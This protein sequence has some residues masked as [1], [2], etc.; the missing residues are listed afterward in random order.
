MSGDK[1]TNLFKLIIIIVYWIGF[2]AYKNLQEFIDLL[3]KAGELKRISTPVS[4]QLEISEITDRISKNRGPALLF[5]NTTFDFPVLI[6]AFGSEKRMCLALGVRDFDEIGEEITNLMKGLTGP[7]AGLVDKLKMLPALREIAS[8]MPKERKGK[9]SCQEVINKEPDLTKIPVITCWPL[10]GGPYI[11]LPVVH[12]IDPETKIRNVGMYRMQVFDK[13][14]TGMHWQ[15]HKNSARHYHEYKKLGLKMPVSVTLGGDPVYT[16]AATAPMPDNMDEYML[17][18]FLRKKKVELVKCIT[19]DIYVPADADFVLEGYVDPAEDPVLEGPFGDHTG[20]YSLADYYPKFHITC[21]TH[22]KKAI[23]PTT[24]VG[25]PPQEDEW[26]G[27]ATERIFLS[28]IQMTMLPEVVDMVMPVEGVFHNIAIVK[29]KKSYAGQGRKVAHSLWGAGQ[30]M[31]NKVMIVLDRDID[32]S[33]YEAVMKV[34]NQTVDPGADVFTAKGPVDVLDHASRKFAYGGKLGFDATDKLTEEVE[35]VLTGEVFVSVDKKNISKTFPEI[36]NIND[37]L[38]KYGALVLAVKKSK[39]NHIPLLHHELLSKGLVKNIKFIAYTEHI[40]D[41]QHFGDIAW[42]VA[43]NL[44]PA[45][46]C[47]YAYD[48]GGRPLYSLAIDGTRKY[49]KY[50]GFE[51]EWPNTVVHDEETIKKVDEKWAGLGLG[52][53]IESPS[54]KYRKQLYPGK[55]VA[56]EV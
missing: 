52:E 44:D 10:D 31:F 33:D 2:M 28:P 8:W 18:G 24:I 11:T 51:R 32:I 46:D 45:R 20:F 56:E 26:L 39:V 7:K 55:D 38:V 25:V 15:L 1:E 54:L 3:E 43:N 23:Y 6:N 9:G 53:F 5:E 35:V 27:K 22:R 21:I 19:N 30:M 36:L 4:T 34:M 13:N 12:T 29:I 41:L 17:A 48:T 50:D 16:Y 37:S 49:K 42:R 14:I 47:F 40:L